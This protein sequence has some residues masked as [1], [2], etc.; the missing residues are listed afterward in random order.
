MQGAAV[1][2]PRL[3]F[4]TWARTGAEG[5][6]AI[7]LA[8]E[9]GYRHIDTAQS[10]DTEREV[11]TAVRAS[12][13]PRGDIWVTTKVAPHNFG[14]GL[15]GPSVEES[16]RILRLD[17]VDLLLIHWPSPQGEVP[18]ATYLEQLAEVKRAGLASHIGVSNFTI[19][20]LTQALSILGHGALLTNQIELNPLF[21]NRK[22]AEF[23]AANDIVTT[24][25]Q[26]V[27]QGRVDRDPT[28]GRIA[29][30]L[31]AEPGQVALAWEMAMGHAAIPTSSKPARIL[32]NYRAL[33]L[34]LSPQD[35]KDIATIAPA[36]RSIN[37][38]WAPDWD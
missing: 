21:Q 5:V 22:V 24:C 30:R 33:E 10:Y 2:M 32:S 18:L 11:G 29:R 15:L 25:Y 19:G 27:A 26:P 28:L 9:T 3:G 37:P 6:R 23:C 36:A 7:E 17:R 35:I 1:K 16:L 20:L 34:D 38:D 4:G 14:P 8:L 13:L 31:G 12:G